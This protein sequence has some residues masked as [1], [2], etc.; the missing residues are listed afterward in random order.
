MLVTLRMRTLSAGC[1][2]RS[3]RQPASSCWPQLCGI[4]CQSPGCL[5]TDRC[6]PNICARHRCTDSGSTRGIVNGQ[7]TMPENLNV[8]LPEAVER[9]PGGILKL[10]PLILRSLS[11]TARLGF[12]HGKRHVSQSQNR[13][14]P[15]ASDYGTQTYLSLVSVDPCGSSARNA[16]PSHLINLWQCS[17]PVQ[18]ALAVGCR[19]TQQLQAGFLN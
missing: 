4:L 15:N 14:S 9:F 18:R 19:S 11:G 6:L 8:R 3:S 1:P 13:K 17:M 12:F 2:I 7:S 10:L 5:R 16:R